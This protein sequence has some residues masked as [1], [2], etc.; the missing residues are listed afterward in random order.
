MIGII[1][2]GMGNLHSV[3]NACYHLQIEALI[4]NDKDTLAQCDRLILPGVGAMKDCIDTLKKEDLFDWIKEQVLEHKK[5]ILGICLGMQALFESSEENGGVEC[6]GFLPGKVILMKDERL[7][8]PHIGWNSLE[9]KP[10]EG[11][12]PI[13]PSF[14][15]YDHSYYGIG[16]DPDDLVAYS[17][18]G[19]FIIPG[20]VK[21][22]H[23]YGTQF[24]PEKSGEVGLSILKAFGKGEL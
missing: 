14:V 13:E 1:D 6:F 20:F 8:I 11:Y 15:Y 19:D 18:Y 4:S 9:W 10:M 23:I 2:Y 7:R 5:P 12:T 22:N 21:R 3:K 16:F 24:H 17:H